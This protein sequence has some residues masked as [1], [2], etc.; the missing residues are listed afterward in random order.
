MNSKNINKNSISYNI[1]KSRTATFK[2]IETPLT[3]AGAITVSAVRT[4]LITAAAATA[5]I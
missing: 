3:A 4:T 5:T 1:I 2:T